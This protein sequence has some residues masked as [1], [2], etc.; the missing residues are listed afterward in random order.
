[1]TDT[2]WPAFIESLAL[3][4]TAC[5]QLETAIYPLSDTAIL[6]ISGPD[7]EK[8][9]QGQLSC[10]V[11]NVTL[12]NSGLGSHSTPKGRMLSSFR[13]LQQD[14]NSYLLIMH[15][16]IAEAAE[17]ALAKYIV[18]SKAEISQATTLSGIA[19]H[20][21]KAAANLQSTFALESLPNA[22]YA[23]LQHED[24]II[25][26]TSAE[27][28]SYEIYLPTV[29]AITLWPS[30][31]VGVAVTSAAQQK[32]LQHDQ[33]L[34]FVEQATLDAHIPQA[35]NYQATSAISFKKG[36]YTGQEIV[37]RMQ[38]LGKLKRHMYHYRLRCSNQ[39]RAG[40][41]VHLESEGKSIGD[42]V[43]AVAIGEQ[44]WDVLMILTDAGAKADTLYSDGAMTQLERCPLPYKVEGLIN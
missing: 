31:S 8:F 16:S 38:Y 19:L 4:N 2:S 9:L 13:L 40:D 42:I 15:A 30:L 7:A 36:C 37:A 21:K 24:V 22:D 44:A 32:L 34:A 23:Q 11:S 39:L 29:Q 27:Q 28:Q 35:F 17:K 6:Q 33:G 1:M 12:S 26:C 20:G 3:D 43:S 41:S 10:D 14:K 25:I 18:F 5:E